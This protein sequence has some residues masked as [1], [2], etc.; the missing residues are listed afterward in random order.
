MRASDV[1][2]TRIDAARQAANVFLDQIPEPVRV[3]LV[4]FAGSP[5]VEA[6]PTTDRQVI[7][8]A[9]A[10]IKLRG[11]TA[12][13]DALVRAL[14]ASRPPDTAGEERPPTAVLLLTDGDSR[15]GVP[16]VAAAQQA[17]QEGVPVFT[18]GIAPQPPAE[19]QQVA[20]VSGGQAFAAPTSEQLTTVYRDLGTR[21]AYVEEKR[22]LT[23]WFMGGAAL[24]LLLGAAASIAWFLRIP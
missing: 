24:F 10:A 14:Q 19:L 23:S 4:T 17:R 1:P 9:L 2:P 16:P 11:G 12:V 5:S 3:G 7:R 20:A 8:D 15:T 18:V 21:L 6:L 22:E 13:G